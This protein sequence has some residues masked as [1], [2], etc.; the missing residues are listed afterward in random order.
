M[1]INLLTDD[2]KAPFS[3]PAFSL[4][5]NWEK[6]A[7]KNELAKNLRKEKIKKHTSCTKRLC[8]DEI[9]RKY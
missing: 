3:K 4:T 1:L 7:K 5:N 9:K 2:T 8:K 6:S